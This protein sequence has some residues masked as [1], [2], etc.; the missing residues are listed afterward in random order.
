MKYFIRAF[1][2]CYYHR[3][4]ILRINYV[5]CNYVVYKLCCLS[6]YI[7]H[8]FCCSLLPDL[9]V[10]HFFCSLH[11]QPAQVWKLYV[12]AQRCIKVAVLHPHSNWERQH[13][14]MLH[15]SARKPRLSS[16]LPMHSLGMPKTWWQ[17]HRPACFKVQI[18]ARSKCLSPLLCLLFGVAQK[19]IMQK[20]IWV[21]WPLLSL[22][23]LGWTE[24][25]YNMLLHLDP[26]KMQLKC[27]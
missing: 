27:I 26:F 24:V 23:F 18:Y 17:I 6:L 14:S 11:P 25:S 22:K 7:I 13:S 3:R 21:T 19:W 8:C 12:V 20:I 5:I 4:D 2:R 9:S 16:A 1:D 10:F 15:W